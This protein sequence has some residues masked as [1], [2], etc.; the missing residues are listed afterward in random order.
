MMVLLFYLH[1]RT[2]LFIF[3]IEHSVLTCILGAHWGLD[4][5]V[6]YNGGSVC[7]VLGSKT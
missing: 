5:V 7:I 1:V 4:R 2:W 3:A 6:L